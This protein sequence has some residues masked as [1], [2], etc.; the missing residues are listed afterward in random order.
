MEHTNIITPSELENFAD[1]RDSEAVIPELIYWLITQSCPDLT[2]C[3]IPYGDSIG[4]PGLDGLVKTDAGFRQYVPKQTSWWEIGTGKNARDKATSD[5]SKRLEK[6]PQPEDRGQATFVFA[7]P[8]SR[9]WDQPSQSSWITN[10]QG[11]GWKDVKVIDGVRLC[12]WLREFPV[13]GKWLLQKIGLVRATTGFQTPAER[14]FEL[15]QLTSEGGAPFSAKIFLVGRESACEELERLFKGETR[16]LLLSIESEHDAEDFVAAFLQS[17]DEETR[18][19]YGGRCLFISD[20]EAWNTFSN[21]RSPH[22]LVASPRLDLAD[23]QEHLHMAARSRGH[24][25]V[26]PVSASYGAEKFVPLPSPSRTVLEATLVEAGFSRERAGELA[27]AGAQSLAALKRHL[28]GLGDLPPYATWDNAR[29]LAQASL[30]GKWKG[31]N[32]ADREAMEILLGKSYGEWIEAIRAETL[33]PDTPLFQRNESWKMLSRGEA[34]SALGS[35]VTDAD[36]DRFEKLA[37][38]VLGEQDPQFEV[39]KDERLFSEK[40]LTHS[41]ALR[42][43]IAETL[44]LLG[45][46]PNALSS[47]SQGKGEGTAA[48]VVR[49]LLGK[50]DW[51]TWAS[52]N[53]ELPLLAEAA[54]NAFLDAVETALLEPSK[55]PFLS[56]YEQEGGNGLGGWN[57]ITGVLWALETLAWHPDY[58]GRVTTLLADLSSIDPGGTWANRPSNSL[59]DIYLPWHAQT[60]ADLNQRKAALE[61]LLRDHPDIGWKLLLRLLPNAH[62]VTTGT[63]KP[64]W[65]SFIPT[66]WKETVT[67]G[68]YWDQ[69][70]LYAEMCT[71]VAATHLPKLAELIDRLPDIPDLAHSEVLRHLSSPGI[72]ALPEEER[73]PLWESLQDLIS[74]HKRF[75]DA[76]WAM[77]PE[78]IA[79][80]D[81]VAAALAPKSSD[82]SSRR[83]FTERDFELYEETDNYEVERDKLEEKRRTAVQEILQAEGPEGVIRFA[84]SVDAPRKVGDALGAIEAPSLDSFLLPSMLEFP[85]RAVNQLVGNFVWR[86]Y[87]TKKWPWVEHLL[88]LGWSDEHMLSLL[89]LVP[90]EPDI[91]RRAE[92]ILGSKAADYWKRVQINPWGLEKPDDLL[93]AT[94]KLSSHGRPAHAIDCLYLLSHKKATIPLPLAS[95]VLLGVLSTEEEQKRIEPHHVVEVIKWL[96]EHTADDSEEL[97]QIEWAYLPILNRIYGAEPRI[98]ERRLASSP[99]FFC[100]VIAAVFRSDKEEESQERE[101]TETEKQTAKNAYSLLHGWQILPGSAL[102][103]SFDGSKFD[104]WLNDVKTRSKETGHF[105][106]AMDQLGQALAYAPADPGGLWIH[107]TIAAALDSREAT[108]MRRGF[109]A[110]LFNKR[111]VHGFSHGIEEKKIADTYRDKAKAL[112]VEGLHRIADEVRRLAESYERD[113]Q[114]ESKRDIIDD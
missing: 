64:A 7:T 106:I 87:W 47:T 34:W 11:D 65:R 101:V 30:A 14:W 33:R 50:A 63:R 75:S 17:L 40:K 41:R 13:I 88:T 92:K 20:P 27:S 21:L 51:V 61:A 56:V 113:A 31:N 86:R 2:D 26:F 38:R 74:K 32:Q 100:E 10:R 9:D 42:E 93:E 89:L 110:G 85:D 57:Y 23:S 105:R 98:L 70:R 46:R 95:A 104:E 68:E 111:G 37:I 72:T 108:E 84:K 81:D 49:K 66:G 39:P 96:E 90:A 53:N 43:G 67:Q 29:L 15:A 114:R 58:L 25:I 78:Q 36:L 91:W 76:Q 97:F 62:G 22:V 35:R 45:A 112:S 1:R 44:A 52:L 94:Q 54:P 19:A 18:R 83:L 55:S 77:R 80:I 48:I 82:L 60:L 24:A 4:L 71:R 6:T 102:D 59:V 5:Y 28:R 8:R 109:T 99:A 107:K 103:G 79:E 16:Q 12:D 73:L 3:R 69:A